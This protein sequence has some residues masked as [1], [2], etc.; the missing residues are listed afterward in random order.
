MNSPFEVRLGRERRPRCRAAPRGP[1]AA[2]AP[3]RSRGTRRESRN[4][5]VRYLI[6]IRA[7]SIA[8][9]EALA[10]RRRRDDRH[11]RLRVAPVQ[12]HQQVGLLGLRRHPG[13]RARALDV[14]DQQRQLERDREADRLLLQ[15]DARARPTCRRRARRRTTR[16][17][18]APTAAISSSA[19]N[20][21]TPKFLCRA[22]SSRIA[23]AGV[24][25]YA[26]RKS[27]S[28][29]SFD[30]AIRPYASAWL[31]VMLRYVPGVERRRL[32]LVRDGERL[33][34]LAERVAGLERLDVRVADVRRLREL[35][36]EERE[37]A[38]GRAVEE[39]RHQ[40]EREHVLRALGLALRDVDLLQR[41]E[42]HRRQRH[43]VHLELAERAVL[44]R[45]RRV[46]GL[47]EV[48]L[49][50]R[51]PVDDQRAALDEVLEVRLQRGR[52]H[53]DE[54]VRPVAGREDVVVG[55]VELEAGDAGQRAGG[56]ADLGRDSRGRSRGR[57][58]AAPSRS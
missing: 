31:P 23:D 29:L 27:G 24:I 37:R 53:R 26:P 18:A 49:G 21:R 45:V 12:H 14:E 56:R 19:W 57:C 28:P 10:G 15:H 13:R 8:A 48:P 17:R 44:E 40:P 52:V 22:S 43:V 38:L 54:H 2:T 39:P 42:R 35:L 46:A 41:L 58:R 32:H 36:L 4:T 34:R 51:V 25:G 55:E 1:A 16:R 9:V 33:G 20:V 47:V 3:S 7:A 50:E 11:R 5:G 30:A 6:A